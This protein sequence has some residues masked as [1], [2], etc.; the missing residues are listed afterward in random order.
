MKEIIR[1]KRSSNDGR[2][3]VF[4]IDPFSACLT[5]TSIWFSKD[6]AERSD[7]VITSLSRNLFS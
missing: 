2:S 3:V 6:Q 4:F 1:K 7:I 5:F